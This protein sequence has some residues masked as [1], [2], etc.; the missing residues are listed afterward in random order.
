VGWERVRGGMAGKGR[1]WGRV[2]G[3]MAGK[4]EEGLEGGRGIRDE[5][6]E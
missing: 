1:G 4:E 6:G 5:G 3:G 2:R